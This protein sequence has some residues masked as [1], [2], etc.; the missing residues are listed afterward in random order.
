MNLVIHDPSPT[1]N[2][3]YSHMF[4]R[5]MRLASGHLGSPAQNTALNEVRDSVVVL[6]TDDITDE[7]ICQLKERRNKI[8]GFNVTDSAYFSN[9]IRYSKYLELIDLIFMVSGVP[10][11]NETKDMVVDPDFTVRLVDYPFVPDDEWQI[12]DRMRRA[13][14]LQSLPYMTWSPTPEVRRWPYRERSQKC[15]LRGGG[16]SRRF[17]LAMF[18]MRHDLLDPNSGFFLRDYFDDAMNPAFRFCDMCRLVFKTER[19]FRYAAMVPHVSCNSPVARPLDGGPWYDM[20][21]LGKWNNRCP[22]S[23]YW[24]ADEFQKRY[25]PVDMVQIEKML[26][27]RFLDA[28]E[29]LEM[30][31]RITFTSDLKWIHSIYAPQR[32]WEAASAGCINVLPE[33][34]MAQEFFPIIK[35]GQ[36]Y[37]VFEETFQN[38]PLAFSIDEGTYNEMAGE[39]RQLYERWL[40]AGQFGINTNLLSHI[41]EEMRKL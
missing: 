38:L 31:G 19:R 29:H 1:R 17:L 35:P 7:L 18:L 14:K 5:S 13:G 34:T 15:I 28:R 36:H 9:A 40:M 8:V 24:M 26:N 37:L 41:F 30:L 22:R 39:C 21:D 12:F 23:F 2:D 20:S 4:A 27:D 25:G 6:L 11:R 16:H 3:Y 33:R 32:F 10:T